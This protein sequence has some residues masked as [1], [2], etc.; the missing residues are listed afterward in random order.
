[1]KNRKIR[2]LC[3]LLIAALFA[4]LTGCGKPS[5]VGTW[6]SEIDMSEAFNQS[7]AMEDKDMARFV[8][9]SSLRFPIR[10]TF[11]ANGTCKTVSDEE[12]VQAALENVREELR[13]GYTEYFAY[14]IKQEGL[15]MTVD[16]LLSMNG[17]TMNMILDEVMTDFDGMAD[18]LVTTGKWKAEDGKL[19]MS[20]GDEEIDESE[21]Y[22]YE[23]TSDQLTLLEFVSSNVGE[24]GSLELPDGSGGAIFPTYMFPWVFNRV[25]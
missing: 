15:G 23:L 19:Y 1:M 10:Y 16:A 3:L 14:M 4:A 18:E 21:Y 20:D 8:K 2:I 13:S 17:L 5:I 11:K 9:V 25:K 22:P 7:I 24:D 6:E 12:A